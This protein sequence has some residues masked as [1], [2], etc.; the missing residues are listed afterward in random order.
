MSSD[1]SCA[2]ETNGTLY[3]HVAMIMGFGEKN[4]GRFVVDIIRRLWYYRYGV[5]WI[6]ARRRID[7]VL[8]ELVRGGIDRNMARSS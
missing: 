3:I 6:M 2:D 5:A 1:G 4:G 7:L 8:L